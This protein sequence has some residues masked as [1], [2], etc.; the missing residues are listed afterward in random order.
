[1]IADAMLRLG[2]FVTDDLNSPMPT[3]KPY[4][5]P[6]AVT[7]G[8]WGFLFIALVGLAVIAL[9][10]DL[11]RRVRRV[12]YREEIAQRLDAEEAERTA[13]NESAPPND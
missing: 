2:V 13:Q 3:P 9:G 5:D 7:P 10:I 1:M 6:D 8:F 4:A 12:R 11:V